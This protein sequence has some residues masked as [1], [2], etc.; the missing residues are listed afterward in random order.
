MM[1]PSRVE[2]VPGRVGSP[3]AGVSSAFARPKSSSFTRPSG[4]T[5]TLAGFRSR[6]MM[7]ASCAASRPSAICRQM[8]SASRTGERARA[9]ALGERLPW[10]EL[11]HEEALAVVFLESV[12]RGDPRVVERGEHAGLTLESPQSLGVSGH[13]VGQELERDVPPERLVARA[14]DLAHAAR[15]QQFDDLVAANR[16]ADPRRRR[17][18]C[19]RHRGGVERGS[20][21]QGRTVPGEEGFQLATEGGVARAGGI[22]EP[23]AF[24][25]RQV[26]GLVVDPLDPRP[27]ISAVHGCPAPSLVA[28]MPWRAAS[29]AVPFEARRSGPRRSP[30]R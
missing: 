10:N 22:K 24:A 5:L 18:L 28:A 20:L 6:W 26:D 14:I 2:S 27:A 25:D 19:D 9:H 15:S 4:S 17:V 12:Q 8:S 16:P 1:A 30:R 23:R 7:P 3:I 13:L 29:H 21:E 11:H